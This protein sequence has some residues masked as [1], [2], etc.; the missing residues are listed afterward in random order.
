MN[1]ERLCPRC[2]NKL[3][4]QRLAQRKRYC[5]R[6]GQDVK[7]EQSAAAH[8]KRIC[9]L[10]GLRPGDYQRLYEAQGG[11]CAIKN[12]TARGARLR[13]AVDHDHK[14]GFRN[15]RAVRGLLCKRHNNWIGEAGD[16]P[17][18]FDSIANYLRNPPA[19]KVLDASQIQRPE[20][21][22]EAERDG[23]FRHHLLGG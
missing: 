16:D 8:E 5:F 2:G 4:K 1:P 6:C 23:S 10:Y 20:N 3:S 21:F 12:C 19:R 17:E 22:A 7:R 9:E 14:L 11:R 13:L 18:V 15:R